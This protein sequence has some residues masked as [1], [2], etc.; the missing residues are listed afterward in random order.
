[1]YMFLSIFALSGIRFYNK[2]AK[3]VKVKKKSLEVY[4]H[5]TM[6]VYI[7]VMYE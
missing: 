7:R 3:N 1:M 6:Y 5:F 2:C 4:V